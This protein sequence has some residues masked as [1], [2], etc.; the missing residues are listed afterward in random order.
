[1]RR[2][3]LPL[4]V[5]VSL[6]AGVRPA[7]AAGFDSAEFRYQR[8]LVAGGGDG[9]VLLEPDGALFE[10]SAPGFADLR[11]TDARGREV[12]WRH[13]PTGRNGGAKSV[14]VINS[15]RQGRFAIALLDLGERRKVRDRVELEVS[16]RDFVGRAVVLGADDRSGP[17]TRLSATGIYDVR[18]ARS[19]HST[20]AVFPA[21]DFRYLLVRASGVIRIAGAKVSGARERPRLVRRAVRSV[22]RREGG[23][24]TIITLDLGIRDMPV[25]ELRV[26]AATPRYERPVT[27]LGSNRRGRLVPLAT[28]RVFR[29]PGSTSPP[30]DVRAHHRY[31]RV[32]I[33]NG[34]DPPLRAI[35]VSAW[36][37]SRALLVEGGRPRPYTVHYGNPVVGAPSYDFARLP[38]GAIAVSR[39]VPGQF[40]HER[41]TAAFE[42][43][44]DTRSFAARNPGI[45]TAALVLAAVSLGAVGLFTLRR[46]S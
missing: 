23:T 44:P 26:G 18:G 33:E 37:R 21:S 43:P 14:R 3:T 11:V 36:S 8:P 22:S 41:E 40:G 20:T 6:A 10:H 17:F 15:G 34:D 39:A 7:A 12:P 19:A 31:V 16:G 13:G 32:E 4:V 29:F 5:L 24:R 35:E 42:P 25:D 45:V 28:A 27:V 30:I 2:V 1:M 9:P 38:A 46:R